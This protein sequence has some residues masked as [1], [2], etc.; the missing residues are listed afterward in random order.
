MAKRTRRTTKAHKVSPALPNPEPALP[1]PLVEYA[2]SIE[3]EIRSSDHTRWSPEGMAAFARTLGRVYGVPV[4]VTS[5]STAS[6]SMDHVILPRMQARNKFEADA[7][8]GIAAHEMQHVRFGSNIKHNNYV[9][10][11][12][13]DQHTRREWAYNA[14][15]DVLDETYA[16]S[17]DPFDRLR[18]LFD[19]C[20]KLCYLKA[21]RDGHFQPGANDPYNQALALGI[22]G[23]RLGWDNIAE[24]VQSAGLDPDLIA[25]IMKCLDGV[26]P[27]SRGN[28]D[29]N[30]HDR[31]VEY[32][33]DDLFDML[34]EAMP[35]PQESQQSGGGGGSSPPDTNSQQSGH[36]Q[37]TGQQQQ[38]DQP[39]S[40]QPQTQDQADSKAPEQEQG[41]GRG[42]PQHNES[43]QGDSPQLTQGD[44][45][46]GAQQQSVGG[47]SDTQSD[48]PQNN[49]TEGQQAGQFRQDQ[50]NS[51]S[52]NTELSPEC[53]TG[54]GAGTSPPNRALLSQ[55]RDEIVKQLA[56]QADSDPE[57]SPETVNGADAE[58]RFFADTT[59]RTGCQR[60]YD[61]KT[62]QLF[63]PLF[64][65]TVGQLCQSD[66][67]DGVDP[68]YVTGPA[69]CDCVQ[70]IL[71]D[72]RPFGRREAEG[73][74]A[75]I[76]VSLDI[77]GS[78]YGML[79]YY[80]AT[81]HAFVDAMSRVSDTAV[82]V[83]DSTTE[84][85]PVP[86][87]L[88]CVSSRGGT[89][90]APAIYA[91]TRWLKGQECDRKIMLILTDGQPH[92]SGSVNRALIAA[93]SLGITILAMGIG[94]E[95][96]LKQ[97]LKGVP[98]VD[99]STPGKCAMSLDR[100]IQYALRR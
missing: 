37:G 21:F 64:D 6:A 76:G 67:A 12:P 28:A 61:Q 99:I 84:R 90:L 46:D 50:A 63:R 91:S 17:L 35:P 24:A 45:P 70:A 79:Q 82:W 34:S 13:P 33:A 10:R 19:Q 97:N 31:R 42:E 44:Q 77:S 22:I 43:Q 38:G 2:H 29:R 32:T 78:M 55:V 60:E 40:G 88:R 48:P 95:A 85:L 87:L 66:H 81:C 41:G 57:E 15:L 86:E 26:V 8:A 49:Q 100:V 92:D 89:T 71:P 7:A 73:E 5:G 51:P 53:G 25:R 4:R 94:C 14:A 18:H 47:G 39:S 9:R 96:M 75:S 23:R 16:E 68:G 69:F 58:R 83:F 27:S 3:E 98:V 72:G 52:T 65:R 80:S 54:S 74:R 59:L 11:H 36:Q 20:N 30:Y 93:R 1:P 56:D 62:Y